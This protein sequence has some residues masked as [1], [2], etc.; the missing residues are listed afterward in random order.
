[1]SS[2]F[3]EGLEARTFLSG[4]NSAAQFMEFAASLP[5]QHAQATRAVDKTAP[6][7]TLKA[8]AVTTA[9]G[10]LY[11]FSVVYTDP[12]KVKRSTLRTGNILVTGPHGFK[13]TAKFVSA[14]SAANAASIT[15]TYSFVPPAGA[16][17]AAANGTYT[18]IRNAKQVADV[19][20]NTIAVARTIKTF[21]VN[22]I[23]PAVPTFAKGADQ[24]ANENAG[25]QTVSPWA[26][27]IN[28][29][30]GGTTPSF[31][32]TTDN[33]ALFSAVPAIAADGTLT[34]TP[35]ADAFGVAHVTVQLQN[36]GGTSTA[37]FAITVNLVN[38]APSF[39][40]G[41][42][43]AANEGIGAQSV[44]AWATNIS[45]G[46]ASESG[47]TLTFLVSTD[48]NAI[49]TTLPS[50]SANGTLTY[51]P[52][53]NNAGVAHVTVRLQD[54]GGTANGG[55]NTSAVQSFTITVNPVNRPPSF[56][57]GADQSV[58][59]GAGAR[60]V[61]NWATNISPGGI[62]ESGQTVGFLVSSDNSSLFSAGPT[63]SPNGTLTYTPAPGVTGVAH[64]T[65]RLQD[66][67][68]TANGGVDTSVAQT[69]TINVTAPIPSL[70]GTYNG[71][72]NIPSVGHYKSAVLTITTQNANGVFS[73]TLVAENVVSTNVSGTISL[74]GTFTI[75]VVTPANTNH[76]GGP[77]N[78]TGTGTLDSTGKQVSINLSFSA[79]GTTLPGS[80][81]ATKV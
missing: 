81:T 66:N 55:A 36:A 27:N 71:T 58:V 5:A 25:P 77:I 62:N 4:V 32:V 31:A 48:N 59:K 1:M 63:I 19:L 75:T 76:P 72:L 30:T 53:T 23:D 73:G 67:G 39:S 40:V 61:T 43:Q 51:T 56:T 79:Y 74:D 6:A 54:N 70:V 9:G 26:T 60:T 2:L 38:T 47:Q 78:G 52:A 80:F 7:S 46:P 16:W 35:A 21:A 17:T 29:G 20:G 8:V 41:A 3:F 65:V 15:A 44:A 37:S 42:N 34:Y 49:F 22:I 13:A 64:V 11:T 10:K 68:G 33:N 18:I 14:S 69:F 12:S 45:A 28:P 50:I 24:T 57:K